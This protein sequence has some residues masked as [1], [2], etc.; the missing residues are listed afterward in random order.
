MIS[1]LSQF[2]QDVSDQIGPSCAILVFI[3]IPI[4]VPVIIILDI[5]AEN[6]GPSLLRALKTIGLLTVGT[7]VACIASIAKHAMTN[8]SFLEGFGIGLIFAVM[9]GAI[10]LL[11]RSEK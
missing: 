10:F 5:D 11:R 2:Y 4:L 1:L 3:V 8:T 9:I 7:V 6:P